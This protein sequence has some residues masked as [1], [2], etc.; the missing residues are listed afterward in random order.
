MWPGAPAHGS[1]RIGDIASEILE[2]A[3]S[4]RVATLLLDKSDIP[5]LSVGDGVRI[6]A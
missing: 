1:E 5:E 2:P 3:Y 6:A 4:A